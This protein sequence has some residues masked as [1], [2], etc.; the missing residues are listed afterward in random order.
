MTFETVHVIFAAEMGAGAAFAAI[1]SAMSLA[2]GSTVGGDYDRALEELHRRPPF[3]ETREVELLWLVENL[4]IAPRFEIGPMLQ[5]V[6][7][8]ISTLAIVA[9]SVILPLICLVQEV[10]GMRSV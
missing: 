3:G 10:N 8:R 5:P 4:R 2:F 7:F 6:L 1:F 9:G